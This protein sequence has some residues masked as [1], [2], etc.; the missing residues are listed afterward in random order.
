[1][2]DDFDLGELDIETVFTDDPHQELLACQQVFAGLQQ[3]WQVI[4]VQYRLAKELG[5]EAR[6][7]ELMASAKLVSEAGGQLKAQ[8]EALERKL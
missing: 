6:A 1:M 5:N 2:S 3:E 8:I 4:K 7:E